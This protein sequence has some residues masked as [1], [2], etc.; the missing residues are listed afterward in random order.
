VR[1]EESPQV[2]GDELDVL[3]A[4]KMTVWWLFGAALRGEASSHR[5]LRWLKSVVVSDA[6]KAA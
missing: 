1:G 2:G 3:A 5:M 6:G 4:R